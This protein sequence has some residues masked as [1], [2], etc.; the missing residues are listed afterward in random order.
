MNESEIKIHGNIFF[1]LKKYTCKLEGVQST[2][3]P[4][5]QHLILCNVT[6][7]HI[8]HDPDMYTHTRSTDEQNM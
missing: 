2:D 7:Q 8:Q 4:S 6:S 5:V 3:D 1:K